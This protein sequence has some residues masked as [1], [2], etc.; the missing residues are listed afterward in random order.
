[1]SARRMVVFGSLSQDFVVNVPRL[2][3][4]GETIRGTDFGMFAGGKGNNQAMAAARAGGDLVEVVMVGR[5]GADQFGDML[6]ETLKKNNVDTKFVSKDETVGTGIALITVDAAGDNNIVIAQRSNLAL[7][8]N[9]AENARSVFDGAVTLMLQL[10]VPFEA[11]IAAAKLAREYGHMVHLNPAPAPVDGVIP[12]ELWELV[13][14]VTPNQT[15]VALLSGM[16]VTDLHTGVAAAQK[17]KD[18]GPKVIILTMGSEGCVLLQCDNP[19]EIYKPYS[20]NSVDATAAGDAFCGA[21]AAGW[22]QGLVL[23]KALERACAAGALATT[24]MGA[25][26]SLPTKE[27]IEELMKQKVKV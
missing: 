1:M 17:L 6:I 5:V 7:S 25:E 26:P 13:D 15:E 16:E 24:K 4:K 8:A 18:K 12:D 23:E 3:A 21:L 19:P 27:E 20:V 9:D 14:V 22:T 2:P 11:N 10:E